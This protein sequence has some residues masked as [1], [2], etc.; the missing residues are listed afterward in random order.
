[1][2][3]KKKAIS[4]ALKT[5]LWNRDFGPSVGS[6]MCPVCGLST[7]TQRDFHA[8]HIVPESKGGPTTL[9]NM[10]S[11]CGTDTHVF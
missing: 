4:A 5:A 10:M 7:I 1:M 9:E 11:I 8:G 6:A 2:T 3:R